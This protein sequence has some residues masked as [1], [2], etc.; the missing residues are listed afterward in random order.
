MELMY[1]GLT[2]IAGYV[3]SCSPLYTTA[4]NVKWQIA[5]ELYLRC[6]K[7]GLSTAGALINKVKLDGASE[8]YDVNRATKL[9]VRQTGRYHAPGTS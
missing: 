3:E 1:I 5:E 4:L 2:C 6:R 8:R 7:K 9:R